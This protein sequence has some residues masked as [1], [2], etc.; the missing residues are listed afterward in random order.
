[1]RVPFASLVAAGVALAGCGLP[2]PPSLNAE[3][4][5]TASIANLGLFAIYPPSEDVMLG[6]V[7]LHVPNARYFDLVRI[8][9]APPTILARTLLRQECDRFVPDATADGSS[10]VIPRENCPRVFEGGS[11]SEVQGLRR[12]SGSHAA[13]GNAHA[14]RMREADLPNVDVGRFTEGDLAGAGLIGT[15]GAALG[16]G[17]SGAAAVDVTLTGLRSLTLDEVRASE[18]IEFVAVE[19]LQR[20]SGRDDGRDFDDALTPLMLLRSLSLSDARNGTDTARRFCMGEFEWLNAR[21]HRIV[22]ANRILYAT[23]IA[24]DYRSRD[25]LAAR[26][27]LDL[28]GLTQAGP[29]PTTPPVL[30][31]AAAAAPIVRPLPRGPAAARAE[32]EAKRRDEE[33]KQAA[34]ALARIQQATSTPMGFSGR[35]TTGRHGNLAMLSAFQRPAAVGM[36]AAL[37][38]ALQDAAVPASLEQVEDAQQFCRFTGGYSNRMTNQLHRNLAWAAFLASRR[39]YQVDPAITSI[40]APALNAPPPSRQLTPLAPNASLRVRL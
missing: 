25:L 29:R 12:I 32:A 2:Q 1:M 19:R 36:G 7:F 37:H 22:V 27:A 38:F 3:R 5:W 28:A 13:P 6:D 26:A 14:I 23:G 33:E 10:G 18:F 21:G 15:V 31:A 35:F 30:P 24:F 20:V 11:H 39:G 16:I 9:A 34:A 40:T 8:T 17:R 4:Q